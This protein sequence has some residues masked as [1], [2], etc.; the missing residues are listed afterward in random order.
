MTISRR[1]AKRCVGKGWSKIIDKLYD[2][3]PRNVYVIQVKEKY[4]TLRFYVG[5]APREYFDAI[6]A[7]ESES[8]LTC[9]RCGEPGKLRMDLSWI[10]TSC[11]EHYQNGN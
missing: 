6:E 7:A 11:D 4:G 8:G 9:E 10:K 2:V 5:S 3:K 1:N